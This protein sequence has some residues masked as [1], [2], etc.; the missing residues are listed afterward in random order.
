MRFTKKYKAIPLLLA[1]LMNCTLPQDKKV[2]GEVSLQFVGVN[3][4]ILKVS[5]PVFLGE[6]SMVLSQK[7][8]E[9][10]MEST[11]LTQ[12]SVELPVS[13]NLL[14]VPNDSLVIDLSGSK[15]RFSGKGSKLNS[16]I[17]EYSVQKNKILHFQKF[18]KMCN[19]LR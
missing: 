15:P 11:G 5:N 17:Y 4:S 6:H 7:K 13:M 2:T 12:L 1:V 3:P 9:Y 14:V 8:N 19:S 10:L 18:G 16:L